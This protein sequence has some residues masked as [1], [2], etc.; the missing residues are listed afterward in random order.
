MHNTPTPKT[1]KSDITLIKPMPYIQI[2][3]TNLYKK[4]SVRSVKLFW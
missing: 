2:Y 1:G 3:D 4:H